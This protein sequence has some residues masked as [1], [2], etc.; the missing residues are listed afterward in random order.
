MDLDPRMRGDDDTP[1]HPEAKKLNDDIHARN[2]AIFEMLSERGKG[3]YFPTEGVFAQAKRAQNTTINATVGIALN[4]DRSPMTLPS[5]I[6]PVALPASDIVPYAPIAG[7]PALRTLWAT[8]Q[9]SVNGMSGDAVMSVPV[10]TNGLAH[11]LHIA[12]YLFADEGGRV[13]VTDP[14]WENYTLLYENTYGAALAPF[15]LFAGTAFNIQGLR[16]T[17]IAAQKK[18]ILLF[19]FPNNPTGYALTAAERIALVALLTEHAA[20]GL[21][22]VV[23]VDDAYAGFVYDDAI[24]KTSL[25]VELSAAHPRILAVKIDGASK[26]SFAWGLRVGFITFGGQGMTKTTADALEQKTMGAIRA[27]ISNA[28]LL[29]QQLVLRAMQSPT[30]MAEYR[31]GFAVLRD[32]WQVMQ[33]VVAKHRDRFAPFFSFVPGAGGYFVC[34]RL[35]PHLDAQRVR[36]KLLTEH[37][38][39]VLAMPPLLRIAFS[40]VPRAAIPQLFENLYRACSTL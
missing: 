37:S 16:D 38:T 12:G 7:I 28:S 5:L 22:I 6:A 14:F 15:P 40:S 25:F 29:S 11:G 2:P 4:D 35:A 3:I 19:N 27:V 20:R 21:H 36:E 39:G 8:H 9:R 32:R 33:E 1:M 34:V 10:V 31:A 13:V 30:Y 17:L 23:I 18:I 26:E 24:P